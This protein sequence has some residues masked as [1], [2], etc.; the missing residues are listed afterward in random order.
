MNLAGKRNKFFPID[1]QK[2][3]DVFNQWLTKKSP[4]GFGFKKR[5]NEKQF[6]SLESIEPDYTS[7][8]IK[9]S[10]GETF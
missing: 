5:F 8:S 2:H 6:S 4:T 9:I 1:E 3:Y 7:E 10:L